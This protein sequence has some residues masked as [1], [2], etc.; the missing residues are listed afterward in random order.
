[1][2]IGHSSWK[3]HGV[4]IG[5][6]SLS[7]PATVTVCVDY[8]GDGLAAPTIDSQKEYRRHGWRFDRFHSV[9][10]FQRGTQSIFVSGEPR[11]RRIRGEVSLLRQN[12]G[13]D[14]LVTGI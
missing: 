13:L 3:T 1:M 4:V 2:K 12:S 11:S 7:L 6:S 8:H 10:R 9:S 5:A 14:L